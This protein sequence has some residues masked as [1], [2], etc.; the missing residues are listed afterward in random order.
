MS[1][2]EL[3]VSHPLRIRVDLRG[4]DFNGLVQAIVEAAGVPW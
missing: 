2:T 4:L 3:T 1:D